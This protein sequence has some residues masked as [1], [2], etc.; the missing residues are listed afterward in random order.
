MREIII[1][2]FFCMF[3][4]PQLKLPAETINV[5]PTRTYTTIQAGIDAAADGD[6]VIVDP[7]TYTGPG[8]RDIDF[9]GKA[10]TVKSDTG[11]EN[12]IID[13]QATIMEL[14]RG[15]R[16]QNGEQQDSVLDGLTITNGYAP[17]E[18]FETEPFGIIYELS[19]GGAI[20]CD[21]SSPT[22]TR[23]RLLN[24]FAEVGG[25][26]SCYNSNATITKCTISHNLAGSKGGGISVSNVKSSRMKYSSE[27]LIGETVNLV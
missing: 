16:F 20:F 3:L 27:I 2:S 4:T 8:N 5:G 9:L 24:N 19:S 14:H 12:C 1:L 13:C 26:I 6:T 15:F 25:G 17:K 22:V 21:G 23:C 18:P 10:I 11:P 7:G